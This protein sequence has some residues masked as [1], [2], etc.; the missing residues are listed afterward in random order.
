V[1]LQN[2]A[3]I[4]NISPIIFDLDRG[5]CILPA[6]SPVAHLRNSKTQQPFLFQHTTVPFMLK[7]RLILS[8]DTVS[9]Q[10][11]RHGIELKYV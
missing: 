4:S 5:Q 10:K 11:L 2:V 6:F 7:R 3:E 9:V 1:P 8:R